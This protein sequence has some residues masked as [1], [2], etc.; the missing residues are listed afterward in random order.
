MTSKKRILFVNDEMEMGGVA[1]VLNTLMANLPNDK[2]EIDC[3]VL[4]KTGL[5]LNEIPSNVKVISGTKFFETV[6]QPL[7][8]LIKNM[9][10]PLIFSKL[11]LLLFMKTGLIKERIKKEREELDQNP[12]DI[13]VAAKEGFCTIFTAFGKSKKKINWVLTDYSV[14]NYSKRHM[15]LVKESLEYIDLNIADSKQAIEAYKKVFKIDNGI[16]IHNLM[17]VD[18]VKRDMQE[19]KIDIS[20]GINIVSVAR[21]HFQKSIDRLINAHKYVLDKGIHHNLYL[22]GGGELENKLRKQVADLNLTTVHFLGY[23]KNPYGLIN[24][25]DLFVLSSLYEGFA[26][27]I[28]E[29]LIAQTPVLST[30]VSGVD[31]QII[32]S[33]Y[34]YIV[35]NN[36]EALNEGLYNALKDYDKLKYMKEYLKDYHYPN[37][38]ILEEFIEVF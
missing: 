15:K 9:D 32:D 31:E 35:D 6:D 30:L 17:D 20:E 5:L 29:S 21:F 24:Q 36:Q 7:I 1:R 34:G 10:V 33:N 27:V 28:N 4:H 11:R 13:E 8:E 2:Y 19:N 23:M 25:C 16:S 12:Y 3:L 14:C 37:E 26:T 38:K 18:R 22:V